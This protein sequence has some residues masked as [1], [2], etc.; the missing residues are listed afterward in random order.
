MGTE[1]KEDGC[2]FGDYLN[3]LLLI[4]VL[5]PRYKVLPVLSMVLQLAILPLLH[6]PSSSFSSPSPPPPPSPLILLH[7]GLNLELMVFYHCAIAPSLAFAFCFLSQALELANLLHQ[8]P[9]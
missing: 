3:R 1:V 5:Q 7:W 4:H 6:F 8:P 9:E 2:S